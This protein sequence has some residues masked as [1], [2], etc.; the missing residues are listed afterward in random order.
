MRVQC[1]W[2]ALYP[3]VLRGKLKKRV[4]QAGQ[5]WNQR[6]V[7]LTTYREECIERDSR[8]NRH[9]ASIAVEILKNGTSFILFKVEN[10]NWNHSGKYPNP[11]SYSTS[12][13]DQATKAL[14]KKLYCKSSFAK[15]LQC[16]GLKNS[17][18]RLESTILAKSL[19]TGMRFM[20]GPDKTC[21]Q[22]R[23]ESLQ[24]ILQTH[25][26]SV[27]NAVVGSRNKKTYYRRL[28]MRLIRILL[29]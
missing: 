25:W 13:A 8:Y 22:D 5:T 23:K 10:L 15:A 9:T 12:M 11:R 20:E 24:L 4:L 18:G 7:T 14:L 6:M 29:H 3:L 19:S 28:E 1:F 16:F 27:S 21:T 2:C 26:W 17:Q